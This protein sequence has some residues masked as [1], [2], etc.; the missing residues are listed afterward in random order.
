MLFSIARRLQIAIKNEESQNGQEESVVMKKVLFLIHDLGQGGAEKVLVNLVNNMDR[1]KFD[2]TVMTLF[3]AGVNRQFLS[4]DIKYKTCFSKMIPGNSHLMKALTPRQLHKWLIKD[5]YDIEIA[6]LEGPTT[7]V[8]SGCPCK[9]TKLVSWIHSKP[10]DKKAIAASFRSFQECCSCYSCFDKIIAVSENI[11]HAVEGILHNKG[12]IQVLYN[13]NETEKILK[14]S[15][16]PAENLQFE[17]DTFNIIGVGKLTANKGFDRLIRIAQR[18]LTQGYSLHVYILGDGPEKELLRKC[19]MEKNVSE[20]VTFLGYQTNPYKYVQKCDLFICSSY[21]EG[22][23]TAATEALIVGT[24]VCT[25]EVAGMREMLG[26]NSEYGLIVENSDDSLYEGIK[27]LLDNP[28]VLE[29]YRKQA[30]IRSKVFSTKNTVFSVEEMLD[31][32]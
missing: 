17:K 7:R 30:K 1:T 32:L 11:K 14:L 5:R 4:P 15:K 27:Y 13:T 29:N 25:V 26:N 16:E 18:L 3:D 21:S 9:H 12:K 22:F 28:S 2:I 31:S 23:S 19:A 6:Y 24:P 8:I 20:H 10:K